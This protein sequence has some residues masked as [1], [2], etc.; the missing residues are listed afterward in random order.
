MSMMELNAGIGGKVLNLT[1]WLAILTLIIS[2]DLEVKIRQYIQICSSGLF[3][4]NQAGLRNGMNF[5]HSAINGGHLNVVGD[6]QYNTH[7]YWRPCLIDLSNTN[8]NVSVG[9]PKIL[10]IESV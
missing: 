2:S 5:D 10:L 8:I 4:I 3:P 9:N 7:N 1:W 6:S